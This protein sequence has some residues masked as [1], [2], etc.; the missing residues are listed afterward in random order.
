MQKNYRFNFFDH[1]AK[2]QIPWHTVEQSTTEKGYL[3]SYQ[4]DDNGV[5]D[6]PGEKEA[7][8]PETEAAEGQHVSS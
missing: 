8:L 1:K 4:K 2:G 5:E 3:N 6:E 7:S